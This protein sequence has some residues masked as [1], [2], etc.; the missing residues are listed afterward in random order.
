M[1]Y[2]PAMFF[3]SPFNLASAEK[4]L[5][6][7]ASSGSRMFR[8]TILTEQRGKE[9]RLTSEC[10][11]VEARKRVYEHLGTRRRKDQDEVG[12]HHSKRW[13]EPP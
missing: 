12:V 4:M 8:R 5:A 6:A 10:L 9:L 1:M 2:D 3:V 13:W 11:E 7:L